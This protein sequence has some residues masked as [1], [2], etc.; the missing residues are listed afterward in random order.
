MEEMQLFGS[1]T[2]NGVPTE[3]IEMLF[4]YWKE[5]FNKNASTI[6]DDAR[7]KKLTAAIKAY[8]IDNCKK[9]IKGCSYSDW[10]N[11]RNPG[12][13]KYHD[14]TLIFRNADKVEMFISIYEQHT[15]GEQ[16]MDEWLNS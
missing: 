15:E 10:H 11:G 13:K 1:N 5:T 3:D 7:Q 12:N 14:L 6:L 16:E 2:I 9:A 8:G 4:N